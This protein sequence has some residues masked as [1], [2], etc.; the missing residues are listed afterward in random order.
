MRDLLTFLLALFLTA[1]VLALYVPYF[2][3]VKS[4]DAVLALARS[5]G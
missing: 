5:R 2:I 1:V 4:M 3:C